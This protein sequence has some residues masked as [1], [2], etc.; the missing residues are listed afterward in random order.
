VFYWT[1]GGAGAP[2]YGVQVAQRGAEPVPQG[3]EV[4]NNTCVATNNCVG[5]DGKYYAAPPN[6]S[7][8]KNNMYYRSTSGASTV[9]NTGTGNT[10]SNNTTTI[11]NNPG[12]TDGT[13]NFSLISDFKPTANYSG[14]ASVPVWYDAL[15]VLWS[16]AWDL[17]AVYP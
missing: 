11:T 17:G 14:G 13:G 6:N 7:F 9:V 4:Y 12:F 5:L 2:D 15:G 10:V 3:V 8:A 16:S 1:T